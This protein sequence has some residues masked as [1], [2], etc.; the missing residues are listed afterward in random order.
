MNTI[1]VTH[2]SDAAAL[3]CTCCGKPTSKFY[4]VDDFCLRCAY[5]NEQGT[6]YGASCVEAMLRAALETALDYMSEGDVME[7]VFDY[8]RAPGRK[9]CAERLDTVA[10]RSKQ[11]YAELE[12][13]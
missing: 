12:P 2:E 1:K 11:I 4:G 13:A 7:V 9:K 10:T 5:N 6:L 3:S 8:L